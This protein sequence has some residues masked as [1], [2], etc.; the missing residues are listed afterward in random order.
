M[1]GKPAR[2][3]LD[4]ILEGLEFQSDE[5]NAYLHRPS[6]EVVMLSNDTLQDAEEGIGDDA[7]DWYKEEIARAKAF[8]EN[9]KDYI[10]LPDRFEIDEYRMMTAF[11][12]S[13]ENPDMS[14]HLLL[15]LRGSGAFRRFKDCALRLGIEKEWYAYRDQAYVKFAER[16][17]EDE[18]IEYEP[19]GVG[20]E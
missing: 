11:A 15:A 8:L 1:K 19:P 2:V 17:C 3:K 18:G 5:T 14:D 6:G 9:E 13:V 12:E 7:A 20:S 16:W 4:D 10:A